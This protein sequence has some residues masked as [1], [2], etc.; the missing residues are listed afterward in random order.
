MII[1]A[2]RRTDIPAFYT[3]WL[4]ARL[5]EGFVYVRNPFR[6]HQISRVSLDPEMVDCIVFWTKNPAPLLPH[7]QTLED[8]GYSYYFQFTLTPYEQRIEK[9]LPSKAVLVRTF[10]KLAERVGPKRIVWR[11]DPIILTPELS[12]AQHVRLFAQLAEALRGICERCVISFLDLYTKTKRNTKDLGLLPITEQD[13]QLL[14][15]ELSAVA[16]MF[17]LQ[18]STC[19]EEVDL[20]QW[21]IT[22][23][24]CIDG[25]LIERITGRPLKPKK[26]RNQ[27]A[28]CGCVE[29]VDIGAYDTCL[30]QCLYCYANA[31]HRSAQKRWA[32]HDPASPLLV[33]CVTQDDTVFVRGGPA[34]RQL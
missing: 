30:H 28:N 25:D 33:G 19:A 21:G 2:S 15:R 31:N 24:K 32:E 16:H 14:G 10:Q 23:G 34:V 3:R 18:L 27:R 26:D 13:M 5:R 9:N 22:H 8:M 7:L 11:Y 4:L 29:S 12:I 1:S 6:Y 20:S 17:N